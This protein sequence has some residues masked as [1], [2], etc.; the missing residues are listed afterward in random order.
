MGHIS[1]KEYLLRLSPSKVDVFT[2]DVRVHYS[3]GGAKPPEPPPRGEV[4]AFTK[5]SRQRLAFVASNTSIEF[6]SMLTLTYPRDYPSD[7][8]LVKKHLNSMLGRLRRKY[9]PLDYLWFLEFQKRGAPHMHLLLTPDIRRSDQEWASSTWYKLV[10]SGD[11]KHLA[12]GTNWETVHTP[13]GAKHYAVKYAMKM[14]QKHVPK[15]YRDVGRFWGHS[16]RVKPKPVIEG[17]P[18]MGTD[19]LRHLLAQWDYVD[20]LDAPLSVLYN[21]SVAV[22]QQLIDTTA[23]DESEGCR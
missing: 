18:V 15:G 16:S 14:A 22:V 20:K 19:D 9:A 17:I 12:A 6:L 23:I 5:K 3:G 11:R 1:T 10:K 4:V 13:N 7:G 21:A 8:R 2:N